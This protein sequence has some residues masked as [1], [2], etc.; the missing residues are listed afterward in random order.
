MVEEME[1][2]TRETKETRMV[3]SKRASDVHLDAAASIACKKR[4]TFS[5]GGLPVSNERSTMD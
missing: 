2:C 4:G 5:P 3:M 1:L